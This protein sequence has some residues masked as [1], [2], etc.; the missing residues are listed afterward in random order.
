MGSQTQQTNSP[1]QVYYDPEKGQYF[2]YTQPQQG[3]DGF[4]P[5]TSVLSRIMGVNPNTERNYLGSSLTASAD[6][7]TPKTVAPNYPAMSQLFPALDIG[8]AQNLQQS[9]LAPTDNTQSSGASRFIAPSTS[10]GK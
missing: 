3:Q 9:L 5:M 6:R 4:N 8:L 1:T 7:F 2:T 10:K